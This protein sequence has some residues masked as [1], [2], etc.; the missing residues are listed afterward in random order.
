MEKPKIKIVK[1]RQSFSVYPVNIDF[2]DFLDTVN[3]VKR[4][5]VTF[6]LVKDNKNKKYKSEV[7]KV[8]FV[9]DFRKERIILVN[10]YFDI[11]KN[12]YQNEFDMEIIEKEPY[13][14]KD[15]GL[16]LNKEFK[17]REYQKLYIESIVNSKLPRLLVDLYTGYGKTFIANASLIERGK[18]IGIVVLPRYIDK[19]IDDVKKY[20]DIKDDEILLIKG[21]D[22][23]RYISSA[24]DQELD[25][26]KVVIFS[27]TTLRNYLSNYLDVNEPFK[28]LFW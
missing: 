12:R 28:Y 6:R 3:N 15:L 23:I 19:W 17:P 24:P 25:K 5:F 20:T 22:S 26:Y 9:E 1:G 27:L 4:D 8:F 13:E 2:L 18:K 7:E 11:F 14:V 21:S 10:T 16:T